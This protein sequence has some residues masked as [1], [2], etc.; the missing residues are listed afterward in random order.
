MKVCDDCR[1]LIIS[2][3]KSSYLHRYNEINRDIMKLTNDILIN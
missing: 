1:S 3:K 2:S